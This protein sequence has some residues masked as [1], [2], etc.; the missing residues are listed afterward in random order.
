[1]SLWSFRTLLAASSGLARATVSS[2]SLL[3]HAGAKIGAQ[4]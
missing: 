4:R 2:S 3:F 1:L